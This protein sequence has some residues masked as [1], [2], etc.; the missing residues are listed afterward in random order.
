M[1]VDTK[2]LYNMLAEMPS[3]KLC[4]YNSFKYIGL[5]V[6]LLAKTLH[7]INTDST[8]SGVSAQAE[9]VKV[10][11]RTYVKKSCCSTAHFHKY[12]QAG[13]VGHLKPTAWFF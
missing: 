8:C 11:I 6:Q 13:T 1:I 10:S 9:N 4:I 3:Q 7:T 2:Y 5:F 12:L